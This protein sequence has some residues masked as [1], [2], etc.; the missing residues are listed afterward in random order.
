MGCVSEAEEIGSRLEVL[1]AP[2]IAALEV[3]VFWS[4]A[5]DLSRLVGGPRTSLPA[6]VRERSMPL[7]DHIACLLGRVSG[8][9][10]EMS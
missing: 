4:I 3:S 1:I 7:A 2:N 6:G 5:I 8:C 10:E 9:V